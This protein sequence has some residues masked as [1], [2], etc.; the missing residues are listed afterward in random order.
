MNERIHELKTQGWS[1]RKIASELGITRHRV[2]AELATGLITGPSWTRSATATAWVE[3]MLGRARRREG[4][5]LQMAL[6]E[7]A[8]DVADWLDSHDD[9]PERLELCLRYIVKG[10]VNGVSPLVLIHARRA[11][12]LMAVAAG[13]DWKKAPVEPEIRDALLALRPS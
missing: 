2:R 8:L 12:R 5:E 10:V 9:D 3:Q 4:D 13:Q 11:R 7:V 6:C 1:E